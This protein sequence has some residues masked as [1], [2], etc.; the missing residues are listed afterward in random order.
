M[1]HLL[2]SENKKL[3]RKQKDGGMSMEHRG[4]PERALNG[5]SW[6]KLSNK[7]SKVILGNNYKHKIKHSRVHIDI[8]K[9]MN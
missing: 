8:M 4:P 2:V 9:L 3:S 7:I 6:N 5:Q 1:K